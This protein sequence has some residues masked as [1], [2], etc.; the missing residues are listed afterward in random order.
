LKN[1]SFHLEITTYIVIL[2]ILQGLTEFLPVSSSGHLLSLRCLIV[3]NM[4]TSEWVLLTLSLHMGTLLAAVVYFRNDFRTA[5]RWMLQG[6]RSRYRWRAWWTAP[7]TVQWGSV[8]LAT[9]I[10]GGIGWWLADT[11]E[12]A[13]A[14]LRWVRYGFVVTAATLVPLRWWRP[15]GSV[16]FSHWHMGVQIA[17]LVGLF[18]VWALFPGVSRSGVTI[19]AGLLGGLSPEMAFRFSFYTGIP[20]IFA[21]WVMDILRVMTRGIPLLLPVHMHLL[22]M[23]IAALVGYGALHWLRVWTVRYRLHYFGVY[24]LTLALLLF[25]LA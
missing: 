3:Q 7:M 16:Q 25:V 19:V 13:F 20:L 22:S 2:S 21:A 17:L 18:Q 1:I 8:M 23:G 24:C 9:L 11:V 12:H 10:T 15:R 14:D 5:A 4:H 6:W